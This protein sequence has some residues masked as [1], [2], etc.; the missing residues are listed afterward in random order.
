MEQHVQIYEK[1][2]EKVGD[3]QV[4]ALVRIKNEFHIVVGGEAEKTR[5]ISYI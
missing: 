4:I 2:W 5:K 1:E 3:C